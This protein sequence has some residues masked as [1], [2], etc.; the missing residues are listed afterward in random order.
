[1]WKTIRKPLKALTW[2]TLLTTACSAHAFDYDFYASLRVHGE[3]VEPD[4]EDALDSYTGWRDAYS[5]IGFKASHAF[6]EGLTAYGQ[7]ELPLDVPNKAVQDPWDQDE[8]IRIGK[9]G[10]KG[11]IADVDNYGE[12]IIQLGLEHPYRD[13]LKFFVEYYSEEETAAITTK[14][15]GT[16]ETCFACDGGYVIA[17][18]MRYDLGAPQPTPM[19]Y[20]QYRPTG[21]WI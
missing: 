8:D 3:A 9:I 21:I 20:R 11:I 14:Y 15:G 12:R 10:V 13:D 17:A 2:A 1:M 19:R 7:L 18:G 4:N 6:S 16:A 5:R